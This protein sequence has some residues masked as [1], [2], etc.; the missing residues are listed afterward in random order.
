MEKLPMFLTV[1]EVAALLRTSKKAVY[2]MIERSQ[3]PGV[4][5]VGRRR[6]IRSA[7]LLDWLSHDCAHRRA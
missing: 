3:L 6:L 5:R 7:D 1:A 2:A 4:T